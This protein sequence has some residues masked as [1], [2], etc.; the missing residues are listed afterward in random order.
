MT[1]GA[2]RDCYDGPQLNRAVSDVVCAVSL[3]WRPASRCA[4]TWI[5]AW[6]RGAF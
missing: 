6:L 3:Q 1:C 2:V 5:V 4:T